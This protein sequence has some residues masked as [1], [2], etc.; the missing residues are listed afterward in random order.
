MTYPR[1]RRARSHRTVAL[2][3]LSP[4]VTAVTEYATLAGGP[5]TGGYDVSLEAQVGDV[6]AVTLTG[7]IW[8]VAVYVGFEVYSIVGGAQVNGWGGGLSAGLATTVGI[9]SALAPN[10]AVRQPVNGHARRTIAAG[11]LENGR[12]KLRLYFANSAATARQLASG[13]LHVEN[14]GPADPE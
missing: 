6:V 8:D 12:V 4:N 9:V 1:Y 13:E 3:T 5:G 2:A 7:R 10:T 11:D 14:L